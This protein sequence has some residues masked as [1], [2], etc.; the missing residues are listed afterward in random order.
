VVGAVGR[1]GAGRDDGLH[2]RLLRWE[3]REGPT[4]VAGWPTVEVRR[5]GS[6]PDHP[7]LYGRWAGD[8]QRGREKGLSYVGRAWLAGGTSAVSGV[9]LTC[10][11]WSYRSG[12][13]AVT[14]TREVV[15]RTDKIGY[16]G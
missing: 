11:N 13:V 5:R 1:G 4:V 9:F 8:R 15:N 10:G 6:T 12:Q 7:G 2:F 3:R 14:D 16:T